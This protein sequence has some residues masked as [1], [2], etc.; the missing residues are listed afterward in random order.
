VSNPTAA[1]QTTEA[2]EA[3]RRIWRQEILIA[4]MRAADELADIAAISCPYAS[5][6][7]SRVSELRAVGQLTPVDIGKEFGPKP[8]GFDPDREIPGNE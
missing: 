3:I 2:I 6:I 1:L 8:P 4:R 5:D 7:Q